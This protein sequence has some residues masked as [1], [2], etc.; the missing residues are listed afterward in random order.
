MTLETAGQLIANQVGLSSA[1]IFNPQI[2]AAG[3]LPGSLLSMVAVLLLFVTDLHHMM[4]RALI[5][6][7]DLF[8]PGA[9]LPIGD[10]SQAVLGAVAGSFKLGVQLSAPFIMVVL[11]LMVGL[12]LVAR[13]MPQIQVFF[14][15]QPLQL[16][17]G[18][19][20][21]SLAAPPILLIWLDR[22]QAA[23]IGFL[24]GGTG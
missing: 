6:S 4:L 21:L 13:L 12:G 9:V 19:L 23:L 24:S 7:Y 14:I 10:M 2:A 15:A 8:P 11:L 22:Y 3:S 20:I 1:S 5:G 16:S 17:L 18:L